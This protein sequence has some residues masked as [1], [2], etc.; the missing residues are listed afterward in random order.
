M[1]AL[2]GNMAPKTTWNHQHRIPLDSWL[3]FGGINVGGF[4]DASKWE[5]V[6]SLGHDVLALTETHIQTHLV[7]SYKHTFTNFHTFWSPGV[8]EKHYTGV[9][10][11]VKRSSCWAAQE[12]RWRDGDPCYPYWHDNRLLAAQ[13]W[14]GNGGTS[15]LVYVVY[16]PSG[17]RWEKHKRQNLNSLLDA[18]GQDVAARGDLPVLILGDFNMVIAESP[19]LK[20]LLR[21]GGWYDCRTLGTPA[22]R[23]APTCHVQGGSQI[24]HILATRVAYDQACNFQ[25]TRHPD[26]KSHS[27]LS[28]RM[29]VPRPEQVRRT[30]RG[31]TRIPPLQPPLPDQALFPTRL[32]QGFTAAL[33]AGDMDLAYDLWSREAERLLKAVAVSQGHS[34]IPGASRRGRHNFHDQRRHPPTVQDQASTL[35]SRRVWKAICRCKEVALARPGHRRDRTWACAHKILEHLTAD[36]QAELRALLQRP[37]SEEAATAACT[38]LTNYLEQ[39][40]RQNRNERI[41]RWKKSLRAHDSACYGHIRHKAKQA[42]IQ[43]TITSHG[44]T[45]NISARLEAIM[46]VWTGG[47]AQHNVPA[48]T[49]TWP[50]AQSR[51]LRRACPISVLVGVAPSQ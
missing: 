41:T 11:M 27:V 13:I 24:D 12:L 49:S 42:P 47:P 50:A 6:K 21:T 26:F 33:E 44:S 14:L 9:A 37:A 4:S 29:Q 8:P 7:H 19:M 51:T 48:V 31:V 38:W 28:V 23:Q 20:Q 40:Q 34:L 15:L 3:S 25:V 2:H 22:A 32:D 35:H 46:E 16:G 36:R 10:L 43:V 39:L 17:A 1:H 18:L 5:A 45:A 30:R